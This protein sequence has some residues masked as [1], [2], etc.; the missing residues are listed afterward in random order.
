[1]ISPR[2][3]HGAHVQKSLSDEGCTKVTSIDDRT[4]LWITDYGRTF[5][6]PAL[7]DDNY[8]PQSQLLEILDEIRRNRP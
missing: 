6:V 4:E 1:M 7:G 2:L 8:C 3:I 5:S